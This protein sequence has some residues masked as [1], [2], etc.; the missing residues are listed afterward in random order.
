MGIMPE[1]VPIP[2]V[3]AAQGY[4]E[5]SGLPPPGGATGRGQVNGLQSG[6]DF[7]HSRPVRESYALNLV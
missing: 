1:I 6:D 3:P 7:S 2:E 4:P 5:R